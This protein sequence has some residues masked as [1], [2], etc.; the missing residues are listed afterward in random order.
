MRSN[1]GSARHI[2]WVL[3]LVSFSLTSC[4]V[5][6]SDKSLNRGTLPAHWNSSTADSDAINKVSLETWWKKFKDPILSNLVAESLKA[7][8]SLATARAKLAEVRARRNLSMAQFDP[9]VNGSGSFSRNKSSKQTSAGLTNN[10]YS[11]NFDI[12]WETDIFG[13]L[14]YKAKAA[15][16]DFY[17]NVENLRDTQVSLVAEVVSTYIDL[18]TT[19]HRLSIAQK[20]VFS[21]QEINEMVFWRYQ[22]GLVSD[23]DVAQS[24]TQI[25][26]ARAELPPLLT[27]E[28]NDCNRL[29]VLLGRAPEDVR[30]QISSTGIIPVGPEEIAVDIP[31]D[32]LRQRPDVRAAEYKLK[33]EEERLTAAKAERYPSLN[34]SGDIGLEAFSLSG[35]GSESGLYS[36]MSSI[37]A[38]IFDSERIANNIKIQDAVLDQAR[39]SYRSSILTALEDVEDALTNIKNLSEQREKLK[40]S[41]QSARKAVHLSE[42]RYS[43]GLID[44]EE[45]LDALRTQY[46]LEN[47][48]AVSMG[49][50]AIAQ[51]HLYKALGGG[52]STTKK[53]DD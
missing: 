23:L 36:L 43:S 50:L 10:L 12:S 49:N 16:L 25:E 20:N 1:G 37:T 32:T 35:L 17:T 38:P 7:N 19:E 29:A 4:V 42:Q 21:L 6:Q 51:V 41:T 15:E 14:H 5:E 53:M 34:L 24:E 11:T 2:I 46:D 26:S 9:S 28:S 31:A 45:V 39:I 33:A 30:T 47:R 48:L 52:W 22:A 27:E 8:P 18:R 40:Y 13:S 44:F 3:F